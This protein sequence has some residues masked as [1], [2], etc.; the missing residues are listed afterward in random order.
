MKYFYI[1]LPI[2][3][4]FTS[5]V[6]DPPHVKA[7]HKIMNSFTKKMKKEGLSLFASGG[8]MMG[9]IQVISL[10]Y[11]TCKSVNIEQARMLFIK[12]AEALLYQI[13]SDH[14]IHPYL[15]DY[16]FTSRNIFL[17]IAFCKTDGNFADPP[18]IAYVML[19]THKDLVCYSI[20][21]EQTERLETVYEEPYEEALKIYNETIRSRSTDLQ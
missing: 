10:D 16:P 13:N 20:Y 5:C 18:N 6:L 12:E 11:E 17:T 15:H 21:D 3:L 2:L 19:R 7:A 1:Y 9:D 4:L 8:S 14:E